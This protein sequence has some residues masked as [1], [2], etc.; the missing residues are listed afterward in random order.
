MNRQGLDENIYYQLFVQIILVGINVFERYRQYIIRKINVKNKID[1]EF[2]KK[3][4]D[5]II[6][7]PKRIE[8]L[9]KS[10]KE[11]LVH[12]IKSFKQDNK[13]FKQEKAAVEERYK[14][15]VR[16]LNSLATSG[17]KATSLAHEIN[18]DRNQIEPSYDDI[19]N[20]LKKY[21]VWEIVNSPENRKIACEDIPGLLENNHIA[22]K[23][24]LRFIDAI[25]EKVEKKQFFVECLNI[26]EILNQILEGWKKDYSW[27]NIETCID[28][29]V[30]F[31]ISKD[32]FYTIFDNLILNSV[33]Q[34]SEANEL[35]IKIVISRDNNKLK[36]SYYD[37][38]K[39]LSKKYLDNPRIILE[40][41][42][43]SRTNGHGLGMWIINN[44]I[45]LQKGKILS[46]S[47]EGGFEFSFEMEE[48]I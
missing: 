4:S 16:I 5:E 3:I 10:D 14:Y 30:E 46:I 9:N 21:K 6:K 15:D 39:G 26:K 35:K 43:T 40:P 12:E 22:V 18:N 20:A 17:M 44:T 25:L 48:T 31:N 23:K 42:E 2:I 7:N 19:V 1:E 29:K 28:D 36:I 47:G 38:G 37:D 34:N 41:H 33:Q 45:N 27:L 11:Q 13:K 8:N 32:T 24:I